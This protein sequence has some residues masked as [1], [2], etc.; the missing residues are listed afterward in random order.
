[1]YIDG[2]NPLLSYTV[3]IETP[4]P[5]RI[6]QR[7]KDQLG[8]EFV[9]CNS[10]LAVTAGDVFQLPLG[11]TG[12]ATPLTN[13]AAIYNRQAGVSP[14]TFGAVATT[15]TGFWCQV[16]GVAVVGV[17]TSIAAAI[18]VPLYATA[19]ASALSAVVTASAF[20]R[21]ITLTVATGAAGVGAA[22]INYPTIGTVAD[23]DNPT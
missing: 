11:N 6:G 21:G 17:R 8:R 5:F 2:I 20:V 1:M 22:L 13:A 12:V 14:V 19:T 10:L 16:Q 3:S 9:F 18:S 23:T 7:G 4:M 15:G